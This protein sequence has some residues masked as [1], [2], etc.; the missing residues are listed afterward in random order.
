LEVI[1]I[2]NV[3]IK[4]IIYTKNNN[5]IV[6]GEY[7]K[8]K[9]VFI[10]EFLCAKGEKF[11]FR[12]SWIFHKTY[13]K[14]FKVIEHNKVEDFT[15]KE[16][17][18]YLKQFEGIGKV[19]AKRIVDE[20]GEKTLTV[21]KE[22]VDKLVKIKIPKDVAENIHA[23][24]ANNES[25][26]K[27]VKLLKPFKLSMKT[28]NKI[29]KKYKA[30]NIQTNPYI[31]VGEINTNF[32]LI[33]NFARQIIGI[34]SGDNIRIQA[35]IKFVLTLAS[36]QGHTFLLAKEVIDYTDRFIEKI[37]PSLIV[38][39]LLRL[40]DKK[41]VIIESDTAT[42][43]PS[44]YY[45]ERYVAKKIR[46]IREKEEKTQTD[47]VKKLIEK[48]ESENKIKYD[49]QQKKAIMLSLCEKIL[50]I[51]GGPGTGKTTTLNG[52]IKAIFKKN[53]DTKLELVAP[54]GKAAK[55][56]TETTSMNAKTIHRILEYKPFD[57]E[58]QCGRNEYNPIEADVI[59]VDEFSMVDILLLEKFLRAISID[60]KIIIVG[61]VDQLP[62]VGPGNV[63]AD[64]IRSEVIT[65]VK[66]D[67]IFR[68]SEESTIVKNAF[69]INNGRYPDF[70]KEDFSFTSNYNEDIIA[71][72]L[73]E[74]YVKYFLAKK[75]IQIL[76]PFKKKTVCGSNNLNVLIQEKVNPQQKLKN[77]VKVGFYTYREGDKVI[78]TRNNYEKNCFNGEEG[79]IK[80]I[81]FEKNTPV[82]FV[83]FDEGREIEFIGREEIVELEL[84][85]ALTI[86]KSQGSE[87]EI[88]LLPVVM[89]HRRMLARN[90]FYTGVTRAKKKVEVFGT[91][92]A[93]MTA[94]DNASSS[95]RNSK[96]YYYLI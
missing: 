85:Y 73:V 46:R 65:T 6:V 19:R 54:T 20:F 69:E 59:I 21:I 91:K 36:Q 41:E 44:L 26:E 60:T 12:G 87:Y 9:E 48:I 14:Q 51:T 13:G 50:I 70:T 83:Q 11:N 84:S 62:S 40:E 33:D 82:I 92:E 30:E 35:I 43:L 23:K 45:A 75:N 52:I 24:I 5:S 90:L 67:T 55:R 16:M 93:I 22:D 34:K 79:I 1:D 71:Q 8:N 25:L 32:K 94:I 38:E 88:V 53:P 2:K 27:L 47:N 37:D 61:D 95:K 96:L 74:K 64:L 49:E 39:N 78:Q 4:R 31:L 15:D 63:L 57:G 3:I 81:Y 7:E 18:Q 77:E 29:H 17:I 89:S 80:K 42:Y 68:Q 86:H 58:L 76:T 10:G 28:I 56:I 66:L 72:S